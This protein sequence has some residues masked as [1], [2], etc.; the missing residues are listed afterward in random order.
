MFYFA[1]LNACS[2]LCWIR[3][4]GCVWGS[5]ALD[6][7][8]VCFKGSEPT[9]AW[10]GCIFRWIEGICIW[11]RDEEVLGGCISDWVGVI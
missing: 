5:A 6:V 3:H 8:V 11:A 2:S 9:E 10:F 1:F 4:M 7:T